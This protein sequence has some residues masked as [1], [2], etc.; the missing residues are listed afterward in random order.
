MLLG[1]ARRQHHHLVRAA[2][3]PGQRDHLGRRHAGHP[4]D[5]L[6]P[7]G[8]D[9]PAYLVEAGGARG[10]VLLVDV[11]ARDQHVQHAQGEREVGAGHGLHEHVGPVRGRRPPRV[12]HDDLAAARAQ[13]VE[14]ARGGRHG[15]GEVRPDQHEHVGLLDV[16]ERERQPAVDAEGAVAGGRGRRHAP[17]AVVVDLAGPERDPGELAELVGLLVGQ[18]AAAEDGDRVRPALVADRGQPR[19]D[20]VERLVPVDGPELTGLAVP[21]QRRGEPLPVSDQAGRA[22]ALAAHRPFVDRELLPRRDLRRAAPDQPHPALQ[23][24]VGAVGPDAALPDEVVVKLRSSPRPA[25]RPWPPTPCARRPP[26][27]RSGTQRRTG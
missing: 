7:P 8:G 10:D 22:P 4:L 27:S 13:R 17:A 21:Q 2:E 25:P 18:P 15:L 1:T 23:R 19:R 3:Q 11:A 20:Q 5:P 16:G 24:A 12:D 26:R 6:R 14:V 9:R